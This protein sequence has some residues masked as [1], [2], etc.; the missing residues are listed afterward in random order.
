LK[1]RNATGEAGISET[2][3]VASWSGWTYAAKGHSVH[4]VRFADCIAGL[5]VEDMR[6][7]ELVMTSDHYS[8]LDLD[9]LRAIRTSGEVWVVTPLSTLGTAHGLLRGHV[10]R[11]VPWWTSDD[12]IKFGMPQIP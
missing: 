12:G 1:I 6:R 3:R 8:C 7:T 2:E 11:L 4:S 9:R 5:Y 10:D